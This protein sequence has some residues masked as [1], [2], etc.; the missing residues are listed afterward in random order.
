M[1]LDTLAANDSIYMH[2]SKPPKDGSP[3]SI[4]YKELKAAASVI[5]PAAS[6]EGVHKK[7]NLADDILGWEHERFS[8]RRLPAF[9]LSTLKSHKDFRKYTIMDTRENLDFDRLVRNAK[10]IAEALARHIY[11]VPSG[12]IFG[13][14]WN[15]DKKHIE[16]WINY[17][18]SLPRSPQ[19]LSSKDNLLVATFKDTFNK[20][21]RDV[22]VTNAVPDK[23]DPDFQFYQIASGTVNVYSVKPAIFDLV[24]TIGIIL[25]LLVIYLFIDRLPSLYNLAC[26]FT[27]NTKIKNN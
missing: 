21:L 22:R 17:V 23:R 24:V 10:I 16:T 8:I 26:S 19:I 25:Y 20:Y 5:H 9:T 4:F 13:N 15:V 12:E 27:V 2:V 3:S 18:A 14:S 1:C 7:I 6:V 11:N